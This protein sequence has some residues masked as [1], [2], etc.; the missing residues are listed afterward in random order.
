MLE[1]EQVGVFGGGEWEEEGKGGEGEG[2]VCEGRG[3]DGE[4]G[5]WVEWLAGC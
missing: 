1:G 3:G 5:G 4:V 2:C